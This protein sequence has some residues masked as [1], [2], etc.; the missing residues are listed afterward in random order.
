MPV[1]R[2]GYFGPY[3]Q[4]LLA[5]IYLLNGEPERALDRLEP[6]LGIPFYVSPGWLRLDPAFD[7]L[8]GHPRFERLVAGR[9]G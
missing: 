1:S 8:R 9:S 7:A 3:V 4:L 6:L 2:D 5:R